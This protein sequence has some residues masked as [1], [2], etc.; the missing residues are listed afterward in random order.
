MA[1]ILGWMLITMAVLTLVAYHLHNI[2][3]S[4]IDTVQWPE[5]IELAVT[6]LRVTG[7]CWG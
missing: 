4:T 6:V 7:V 5:C 2:T 1:W 3:Y